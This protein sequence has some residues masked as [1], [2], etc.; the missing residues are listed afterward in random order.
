MESETTLAEHKR[1]FLALWPDETTRQQ[2]AEAQKKIKSD[3][4]LRAAMQSARLVV[5]ENLHM[6]LHFIGSVSLEVVQSLQTCLDSVHSRSFSLSVKTAGCFPKPRVLWLGLKTIPP[7]LSEL[8][9]LTTG[10]VEQCVEGYKRIA[11]RPHI[12]LFRKAK[13]LQDIADVAE[14]RW[15]VGSFA[16]VESK[17]YAEGVQ[18]RVLRQWSL[19]E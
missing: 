12:T 15:K 1:I 11:Y 5:P 13:T 16:L 3:P 8:E 9:Q 14:I 7:E 6:T 2:L 4:Q 10:C 17:T 18:Y 19:A